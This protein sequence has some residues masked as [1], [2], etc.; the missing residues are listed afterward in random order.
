MDAACQLRAIHSHPLTQ[1]FATFRNVSRESSQIQMCPYKEDQ[2]SSIF[3]RAKDWKP[4]MC[5]VI[6]W[7]IDKLGIIS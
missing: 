4:P 3:I 6:R 1:D 5:P 7:Y 2:C